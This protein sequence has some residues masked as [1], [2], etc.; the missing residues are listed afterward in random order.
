MRSLEFSLIP[1]DL[2]LFPQFLHANI[3]RIKRNR[4]G[5]RKVIAFMIPVSL[6]EAKE[7]RH[8]AGSYLTYLNFASGSFE[9]L[10]TRHSV[11]WN[12]KGVCGHCLVARQPYNVWSIKRSLFK[13]CLYVAYWWGSHISHKIYAVTIKRT[14]IMINAI[15]AT[16][17]LRNMLASWFILN[18]QRM[19]HII[20]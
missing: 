9:V 18:M 8:L 13:I 3:V 16:G 2:R 12:C 7:I 20:L 5:P 6:F 17:S 15:L 11:S 14:S 19:W 10:R 1:W 4:P